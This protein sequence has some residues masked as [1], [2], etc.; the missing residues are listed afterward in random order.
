MLAFFVP[1]LQWIFRGAVVKVLIFAAIAAVLAVLVPYAVQLIT[2]S[3]STGI[4]GAFQGLPDLASAMLY[5]LG[6]DV[7]IPA[8]I[9][10]YVTRF[11]IRRIPFIG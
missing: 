6:V 2:P 5:Y 7:G 4:T 11:L 8:M 3:L 9:S 1:V 10:A